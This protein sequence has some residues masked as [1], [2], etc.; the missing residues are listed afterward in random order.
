MSLPVFQ[1]FPVVLVGDI[2]QEMQTDRHFKMTNL[3]SKI[4]HVTQ[5]NTCFLKTFGSG[6]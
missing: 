2:T 5:Q 3:L 4:T 6:S 1:L